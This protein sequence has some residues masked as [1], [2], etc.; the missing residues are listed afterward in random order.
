MQ[1][2]IIGSMKEINESL[3]QEILNVP[4]EN[5]RMPIPDGITNTDLYSEAPVKILFVLKEPYDTKV[6]EDGTIGLGGWAHDEYLND[7]TFEEIYRPRRNFQKRTEKRVSKLISCIFRDITLSQLL[8]ANLTPDEIMKD[9]R[10]IAWIN[11]G[12]FP[13]PNGTISPNRRVELQYKFWKDIL[14]KQINAFNPDIIIF[15]KTFGFFYEDL[16]K[17]LGEN[18]QGPFC[19]GVTYYWKDTKNNR[20]LIKTYHPSFRYLRD[21]LGTSLGHHSEEIYIDSIVKA[22]S[23]SKKDL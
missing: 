6:R 19:S 3:K 12:K 18:L 21:D 7:L 17:S 20:L 2:P 4:S 23:E 16:K 8:N 5:G 10:S 15:G 13:A 22:I 11:V 14:F 9:F 1:K